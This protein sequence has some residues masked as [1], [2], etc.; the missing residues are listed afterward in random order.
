MSLLLGEERREKRAERRDESRERERRKREKKKGREKESKRGERERG[1]P[2][3]RFKTSPV[4][5]FKTPPCVPAKRAHVTAG[6]KWFQ[7]GLTTFSPHESEFR[8]V[9]DWFCLVS[10]A[11][12]TSHKIQP[13][14][15]S[16]QLAL[17]T[18]CDV[19]AVH[20]RFIYT[21]TELQECFFDD[22]GSK[23]TGILGRPCL[24]QCWADARRSNAERCMLLA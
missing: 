22:E 23:L 17:S 4:C 2:V 9:S 3:C 5:R 1:F 8:L 7:T 6:G 16:T 21:R 12:A 14:E 10:A 20:D 15:F 19:N 18:D 13:T 24:R 11:S